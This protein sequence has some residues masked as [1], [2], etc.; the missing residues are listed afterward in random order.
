[1]EDEF[2]LPLVEFDD[3]WPTKEPEEAPKQKY[4]KTQ[5]VLDQFDNILENRLREPIR[6]SDSGSSGGGKWT[7]NLTETGPDSPGTTYTNIPSRTNSRSYQT[8]ST[9]SCPSE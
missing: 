9:I 2:D 5:R 4:D 6:T 8:S 7:V 1:M 3:I